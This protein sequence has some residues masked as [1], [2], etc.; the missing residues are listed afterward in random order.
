MSYSDDVGRAANK[1]FSSP[2]NLA[3]R[4]FSSRLSP[5]SRSSD[6]DS[7]SV[8]ASRRSISMIQSEEDAEIFDQMNVTTSVQFK[9]PSRR[10]HVGSSHSSVRS[11][12]DSTM[13]GGEGSQV[14]EFVRGVNEVAQRLMHQLQ[15]SASNS[16]SQPSV[17]VPKREAREIEEEDMKASNWN[18]RDPEGLDDDYENEDDEADYGASRRSV[19]DRSVATSHRAPLELHHNDNTFHVLASLVV[20]FM[21]ARLTP[22]G[23]TIVFQP[24]DKAKLERV[25]PHSIRMDFIEAVRYRLERTPE[26][27]ATPIDFVTLQCQE[28]G[29][30]REGRH[31]A[32]LVAANLGSNP[33]LVQLVIPDTLTGTNTRSFHSQPSL[34]FNPTPVVYEEDED[35]RSSTDGPESA[36][37]SVAEEEP[38]EE[39]SEE[40][41]SVAD[42]QD[43]A[44][45]E[46][47]DVDH[48]VPADDGDDGGDEDGDDEEMEAD[49]DEIEDVGAHQRYHQSMVSTMTTIDE[50]DKRQDHEGEELDRPTGD[51]HELAATANEN[52]AATTEPE[53]SESRGTSGGST[54]NLTPMGVEMTFSEAE[55]ISNARASSRSASDSL[56][57]ASGSLSRGGSKVEEEASTSSGGGSKAEEN[58]ALRVGAGENTGTSASSREISITIPSL[59]S[60]T[61]GTHH[62]V[63]TVPSDPE[64][65]SYVPPNTPADLDEGYAGRVLSDETTTLDEPISPLPDVLESGMKPQYQ[66]PPLKEVARGEVDTH[67][68]IGRPPLAPNTEIA[69][70]VDHYSAHPESTTDRSL[71]DDA[72]TVTSYFTDSYTLESLSTR[73]NINPFANLVGLLSP[74]SATESRTTLQDELEQQKRDLALRALQSGDYTQSEVAS[75]QADMTSLDNESLARQ[76]LLAELREATILVEESEHPE[77][78][79]FWE[80]H[81]M[82]LQFRLRALDGQDIYTSDEF[83]SE[84]AESNR[85][86]IEEIAQR[87]QYIADDELPTTTEAHRELYEAPASVPVPPEHEQDDANHVDSVAGHPAHPVQ[88]P[89]EVIA[90]R[91]SF[92]SSHSAEASTRVDPP[93]ESQAKEFIGSVPGTVQTNTMEFNGTDY[94]AMPD[95]TNPTTTLHNAH[96]ASSGQLPEPSYDLPMVDVVAPADLPGGY[97]FEAEIEGKR[98]LA[99]VPQGGVQQG[100]TFTCYM[101]DLDSVAIDIP[102]G[103]WRD[104][105][106][107]FCDFGCCHPVILNSL[108][109]PLGTFTTN[110]TS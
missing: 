91:S 80:D 27:A 35:E 101:R 59:D 42:V 56:S 29:L 39:V 86:L 109:C 73:F 71:R 97:H 23:K 43:V 64:V 51:A 75:R 67:A 83:A 32:V 76:Q 4:R 61:G 47:E 62:Q 44:A 65:L 36:R 88:I 108:F 53:R 1:A 16:F 103:Y 31:N 18:P 34:S 30:H 41:R 66:P 96:S 55:S 63:A 100:E 3:S 54:G 84:I 13:A 99:T 74:S 38:H 52:Q 90:S 15:V 58:S 104:N 14:D 110:E 98:F 79:K 28:M 24:E 49:D 48:D 93:T 57:R 2:S 20:E 50:G 102:V 7:H 46:A 85:R 69:T 12:G 77:I 25:L 37:S 70:D 95:C 105:L 22:N 107:S 72:Q 78:T 11:V 92:S 89:D 81:V 94:V 45:R 82:Y 106:S 40:N 68:P 17:V 19:R 26:H 33:A 87:E 10:G 5:R 8:A 21:E 9:K 6:G 60:P